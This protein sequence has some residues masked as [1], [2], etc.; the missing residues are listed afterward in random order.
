MFLKKKLTTKSNKLLISIGQLVDDF[1]AENFR[2]HWVFMHPHY[3]L[4]WD[5]DGSSA[6]LISCWAI[7]VRFKTNKFESRKTHRVS[8][9]QCSHSGVPTRPEPRKKI[10]N[11]ARSPKFPEQK[12]R[13][14]SPSP[15]IFFRVRAG[16]HRVSGQNPRLLLREVWNFRASGALAQTLFK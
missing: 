3:P 1:E 6:K 5:V 8:S 10:W 9:N 12:K 7:L 14:R 4:P 13:K 11:P 15:K 16:F 2:P